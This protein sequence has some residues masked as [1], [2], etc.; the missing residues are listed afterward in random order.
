MEALP[1]VRRSVVLALVM[2]GTLAASC[3]SETAPADDAV[4]E[5]VAEENT[6]DGAAFTVREAMLSGGELRVTVEVTSTVRLAHT[7]TPTAVFDGSPVAG[8]YVEQSQDGRT[9]TFV[10]DSPGP[11]DEVE[12][13]LGP[14]WEITADTAEFR[15]D[16]A[17][18]VEREGLEKEFMS[19]AFVR[20]S[21]LLSPFDGDAPVLRMMV[22]GEAADAIQFTVRGVFTNHE[23]RLPLTL[24]N[25]RSAPFQTFGAGMYD[26]EGADFGVPVSRVSYA[27]GDIDELRGELVLRFGD[28]SAMLE[29]SYRATLAPAE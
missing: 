17:A 6:V 29:G 18:V 5:V 9:T 28:E 20:P 27:F 8:S 25:G 21:D 14:F 4:Y 7:G 3:G 26:I 10:F 2:L 11:A 23:F 24:A 19:T 16:G 15:I 22:V 13:I 1:G 12:L